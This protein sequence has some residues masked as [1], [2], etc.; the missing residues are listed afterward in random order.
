MKVEERK[1][2]HQNA[3][4]KNM[5]FTC[6]A[7]YPLLHSQISTSLSIIFDIVLFLRMLSWTHNWRQMTSNRRS[8]YLA[9]G[10]F[11][12]KFSYECQNMR[13]DEVRTEKE[14]K[15]EIEIRLKANGKISRKFSF[16]NRKQIGKF[17]SVATEKFIFRHKFIAIKDKLHLFFVDTHIFQQWQCHLSKSNHFFFGF[18]FDW[19]IAWDWTFTEN[20]VT[21]GFSIVILIK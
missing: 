12:N 21:T 6:H 8:L 15:N 14:Q 18:C 7:H 5:V 17:F 9:C 11:H 13:S 19:T 1:K 4:V 2:E 20:V 3:K 10:T 16:P